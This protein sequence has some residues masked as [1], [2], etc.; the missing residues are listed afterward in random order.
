MRAGY[1]QPVAENIDA[2]DFVY[3][4]ENAEVTGK[5]SEVRSV[6]ISLVARTGRGDQGYINRNSYRNQQG[7]EILAA[8]NDNFRRKLLT[9][10][11]RC[12]NLGLEQRGFA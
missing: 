1:N 7:T 4:D 11:V 6:Q 2:L 12:R 9:V 8:Q 10:E 5:L 3:L